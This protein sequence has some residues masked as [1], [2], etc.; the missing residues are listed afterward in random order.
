MKKGLDRDTAFER[1]KD[2]YGLRGVKRETVTG[3][4]KVSGTD[5]NRDIN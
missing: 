4:L 3:L 1:E 5:S 2:R